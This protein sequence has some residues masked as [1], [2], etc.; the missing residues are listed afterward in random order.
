MI[1]IL[2]YLILI[3]LYWTNNQMPIEFY[4]KLKIYQKVNFI[5]GIE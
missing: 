1:K 4:Y 5:P 2:V 3:D